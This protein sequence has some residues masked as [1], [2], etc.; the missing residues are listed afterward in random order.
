MFHV[1]CYQL[2]YVNTLTSGL[3]QVVRR[4]Q[5]DHT[6]LCAGISPLMYRLRIWSKCQKTQQ[7]L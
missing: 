4:K 1:I 2:L 3:I 5:L 7:V 6:W